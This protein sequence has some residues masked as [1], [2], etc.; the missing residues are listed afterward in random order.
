L[1]HEDKK[2]PSRPKIVSHYL[3]EK[4]RR[5]NVSKVY[6]ILRKGKWDIPAYF[7]DGKMLDMH[8]GYLLM[9]L[10]LECLILTQRFKTESR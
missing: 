5:A 1:Y 3:L 10:P 9:E 7:G 4:M 8:I 2:I 6:M